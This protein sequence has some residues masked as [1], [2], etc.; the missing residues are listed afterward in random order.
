MR[1]PSVV[2]FAFAVSAMLT[3]AFA[4]VVDPLNQKGAKDPFPDGCVSCHA[5]VPD[6]DHRLN[7]MLG[8]A[9]HPNMASVKNVPTDCARCHKP[10]AQ[11]PSFGEMV[12]KQHFGRGEASVFV[13]KFKGDCAHCHEMNAKTGKV[14]SKSGPKNW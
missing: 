8:K 14:V 12:H 11:K 2:L 3:G 13:Q 6:G 10:S 7:V 5:K 4:L 1:T 9:K